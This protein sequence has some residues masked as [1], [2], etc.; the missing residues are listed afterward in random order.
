MAQ[1]GKTDWTGRLVAITIAAMPA[2]IVGALID[3]QL[4]IVL[5]LACIAPVMVLM[6]GA[7]CAIVALV[8]TVPFLVGLWFLCSIIGATEGWQA[9]VYLLGLLLAMRAIGMVTKRWRF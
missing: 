3:K 6:A 9:G 7:F 4:G 2:G 1:Q 5:F 8:E